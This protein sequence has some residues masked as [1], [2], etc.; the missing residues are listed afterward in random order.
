M[1]K[2]K[3]YSTGNVSGWMNLRGAKRRKSI[4]RGFVLSDHADWEGLLSVVK[5]TGASKIYATHGYKST[6]SLYLRE[7]GYESYE[8]DTLWEGEIAEESGKEDLAS[9]EEHNTNN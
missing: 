6:F 3:P 9:E 4:D 2:F 1:K 7:N 5:E 8:V